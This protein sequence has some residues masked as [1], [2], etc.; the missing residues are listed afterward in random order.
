MEVGILA[1]RPNGSSEGRDEARST[2]GEQAGFR[3]NC[4]K[5]FF[6]AL[7]STGDPPAIH[8]FS[9]RTIAGSRM[10]RKRV[11]KRTSTGITTIG[12]LPAA[13]RRGEATAIE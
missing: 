13:D 8:M 9:T 6:D 5:F 7:V 10:R 4:A 3:A 12:R 1:I 2:C 11:V